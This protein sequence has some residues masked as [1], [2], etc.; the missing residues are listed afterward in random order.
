MAAS[1]VIKY[2]FSQPRETAIMGKII[3]DS[4]LRA[5]LNGLNEQ[6][7]ICDEAGMPVGH[8]LPL[9]VYKK[10]LYGGVEIPL[11]EEEIEERRKEKGGSSLAD[12]WK[13]MGRT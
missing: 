1:G 9:E 7:E 4:E 12:F 5:K 13:R 8:Y 6:L 2:R 10:L 11:S 3:L